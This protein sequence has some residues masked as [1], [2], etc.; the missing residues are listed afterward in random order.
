MLIIKSVESSSDLISTLENDGPKYGVKSENFL[1]FFLLNVLC[2]K[3]APRDNPA[4]EF[5]PLGN[6]N[7]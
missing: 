2:K 5:L 6:N 4:S 7:F 3:P 1:G